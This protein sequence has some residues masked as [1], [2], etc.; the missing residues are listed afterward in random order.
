MKDKYWI[1]GLVIALF[2]A[3][4]ISLYASPEPDGLER[5]AEDHG[6]LEKGEGHNVIE[7]PMPDYII[8]GLENE[9]LAAS[10]AGV[11]GTVII[12]VLVLGIGFAFR[13]P[14]KK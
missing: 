5:V 4:F 7:S 9:T 8:P 14:V 2:M 10:L 11:A 12:F 6:F 13:K 1:I 3:G